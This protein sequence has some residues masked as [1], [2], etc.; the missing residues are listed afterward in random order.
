MSLTL[1]KIAPTPAGGRAE[2]SQAPLW[3]P[4]RYALSV[5]LLTGI[6]V[7]SW[8]AIARI[9]SAAVAMG[10]LSV[11][12]NRRVVQHL[13][14]GIVGEVL[15]REGDVVQAG[16]A[17]LRLD[18]TRARAQVT[19]IE[20]EMDRL[21]A[22]EAILTA[23]RDGLGEPT[24]PEEL[25][26]RASDPKIAEILAV[27][28]NEFAAR[29]GSLQGQSEILG[30]RALQFRKQI[31]GLNV[32]ITS[33]DRQLALVRQE[34]AG[35]E[36]LVRGGLERLPRLLALQREEARLLGERGESI[37]NVGRT[38]QAINEADMQRSQL[39]RSR[40]EEVARDLR[41]VQGRL[42]ELH[43]RHVTA[44]DQLNRID[45]TAPEGGTVMDLR[46]TTRGGVIAPGAQVAAIVPR[47]ERLVV[48]AQLNPNEVD[49][50]RPGMPA[51]IRLSHAAARWT[52]VIEGVVERISPDRM[53]D[54]RTGA[55]YFM[56][57]IGVNPEDLE[58]YMD[59]RLQSGMH[60]E[61]LIRRGERSVA[62]YIV[63]PLL[64]RF[65]TSLR[66]F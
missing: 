63:R 43:E 15:V 61:V 16:Q 23:E 56:V 37:E 19:T 48:E 20:D 32:R 49:T 66:E 6:L 27:Q 33:N 25:L 38:E 52:P 17:L 3:R 22:R 46:F 2:F 24:F 4:L 36:I 29:R 42:F 18:A 50:V 26:R 41:D 51:S 1:G 31:D 58:K 9:D 54:Q 65:S 47:E 8:G 30:Q 11:E 12:L 10:T 34:I 64:D 14:G 57:R 21:R 7:G 62:T 28:R 45:V 44:S 5:V 40:Q 60:A 59:L 55:P 35:V 13:E 39:F 53:V